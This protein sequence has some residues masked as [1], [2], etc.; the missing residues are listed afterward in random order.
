LQITAQKESVQKNIEPASAKGKTAIGKA[1]LGLS[2]IAVFSKVFGFAEKLIVA[3]FFGTDTQADVYFA[4]MGI[5]LSA[6]FL[7]KE[8]IYPSVL[9][10]FAQV[11]KSSFAASSALFRKV[12][13]WLAVVLSV[14]AFVMVLFSDAAAAVL[15]PGFSEDKKILTSSLLR[16]LAPGCLFLC[17]ATLTY[18]VLNC[19]RNFLKAAGADA[20]FKFLVA[21]GLVILAPFMGIYALAAVVTAGSVM[22]F[23][24]QFFFIPEGRVLLAKN[25]YKPD[26]E[27]KKALTLMGP[28]ALGVVF[29][30][31]SGLVDNMLASTL[32]TGQLSFLGYSKKLI[33]AILLV[34]PVALVT[35]VYS[36]LSHLSAEGK[37]DEFKTLFI[38]ALR[39]ILFV[40][41]PASVVLVMLREPVVAALFERGRFTTQSTTGTSQA[42]FIYAAGLV[43]FA[44][45][46]LIVYSFYALSN[47]KVPVRAGIFGVLLDIILAVS[48]VGPF[49]FAAIAWAYVFSKT[50]KV[51]ILLLV[52]DRKFRFLYEGKFINFILRVSAS[53]LVSAFCLYLLKDLNQGSSIF[54]TFAFNLAIPA[55]G[56]AAAFLLCCR[57]LKIKELNFFWY[58]LLRRKNL[59]SELTGDMS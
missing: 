5:V 59:K 2:V 8:L 30:H 3:H 48:L 54:T 28:L 9:P 10:I 13:L 47:T 12:F 21:A 1:A 58:V 15:V 45:E 6:V 26:S 29:S 37:T 7:V 41:I 4:S 19:R 40:S 34:G 44:V 51:V 24:V 43:T 11:L 16:Y 36:Q 17:L 23:V 14:F 56:F 50:V 49:G 52:M 53:C 35:V 39:L 57:L 20:A 32:P 55:A 25:S 42:L 18:A 46:A 22:V 31:I 27:F 33:D 38:R